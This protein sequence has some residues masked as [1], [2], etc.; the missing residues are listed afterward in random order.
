MIELELKYKVSDF[1][2][3]LKNLEVLKEKFQSDIYYDTKDFKLISGGNFVRVRNGKRLEF[4][5]GTIDTTHLYCEEK[6]FELNEFLSRQEDIKNVLLATGLTNVKSANSFEEFLAVNGFEVLAPIDKQ[7]KEF[8]LG[9]NITVAVDDTKG[10]GL[11]VEAEIMIDADR[12]T[13]V[14]A[15]K[16]KNLLQEKL[17]AF[18]ILNDEAQEVRVGYVE[19]FLMEYNRPAYD[20]GIFKL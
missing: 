16:A 2:K 3:S 17:K 11:F 12:L 20:A 5:L 13:E 1:P 7:R 14:E 19:L 9:E 18:E 4:K 15:T 10:L 6:N 8:R